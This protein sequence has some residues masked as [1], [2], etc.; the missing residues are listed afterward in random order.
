MRIRTFVVAVLAMSGLSFTGDAAARRAM[1]IADLIAAVRVSDPQLSPDGASVAYVRTTTDP[2]S[3]QRNADI[4][5]V[6][7]DGSSASRLLAGGGKS[8]T[9]PQYSPDGK[10]LAFIST[11]SGTPQV[12]VTGVG[13]GEPRQ[14]TKLA[15]G[16]Q[17][18]LIFSPDGTRIAFVS[19]VYPGCADEACNQRRAAAAEKNPVKAHRATRLLFRHWSEWREEIR[20]HIFVTN[21][22]TGA[23]IDVTPGDFDSPPYFYEDHAV[24]FSPDGTQLAFVSNREGNDA[25]AWTTNQDVWIASLAGGLV[26]RLTT[27]KAADVQP[28][29]SPDGRTVIVRGQRR[30]GFE[31]DRWYLDVYD[32]ASGNRQT[33]FESPDLSVDDFA[34]APDGRTIVFTAQERGVV[35]AYALSYP[36]GTPKLL[37]RGGAFAGF[38]TGADFVVLAKHSLAKPA[39]LVRVALD[40]GMEKT[41]TRENAAWLEE[42]AFTP[43]ESLT[44]TG[45]GG[46][47]VHYWLVKPPN[48][49]PAKKYP[50]VFL[51]HGGPQ[52]A[53]Q[54]AWSYRWNPQLWAAQ[55]W[56]IAAPNPRGSTGFGQ[57]FVDEISQDWGGKVM[58]DLDA[59]FEAVSRMPFADPGRMGIA[60][61]SYGG[62][63]VNW[64]IGHT[65]RFKVA[66]S[67]D[68]LYNLESM[69]LATEELW[70]P[71]WEMG[72]PP[73][74]PAARANL[75]KW[76]PHLH[77]QK[78]KTPTLVVTNELDFRVPVDQGMQLF[79]A[80]RRQGVPS[81][82]LVFPDE[83]HWVL[84]ALNSKYWHEQVFGWV[85]K[86]M[87]VPSPTARSTYSIR[88]AVEGSTRVALLAGT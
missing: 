18:P 6:A 14:V 13:S 50:V 47:Q 60:G 81:E 45:A 34:L 64:I 39:D 10:R 33:V 73:W 76:S 59:V 28:V 75:E 31:S 66:V 67:H 87:E 74:S 25:E 21:V 44:A 63:A 24:A 83:G 42:V 40:G 41:L 22:E 80:L 2:K 56:L 49:D 19:D 61:A 72:G 57:R 29:W 69:M 9:S 5:V 15:A 32:V 54:D 7:A 51:I 26:R 62:Y 70:F 68:G 11:R 79:T 77:A 88:S 71:E 23:T 3:G 35:N 53:W 17:A 20:H 58:T 36:S 38:D 52:S 30:P 78:M 48:F 84:K 46:A 12:Y 27:S 37:A 82:M 55:G 85:K 16:A 1:T 86:W 65:T 8:E 43:A 4:W